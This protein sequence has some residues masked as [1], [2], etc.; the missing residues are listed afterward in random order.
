MQYYEIG[1]VKTWWMAKKWY[2][3]HLTTATF[4]LTYCPVPTL[5]MFPSLQV[6]VNYNCMISPF[7]QQSKRNFKT[8]L[9]EVCV[10]K[11][12]RPA[13]LPGCTMYRGSFTGPFSP[14]HRL[15]FPTWHNIECEAHL[16]DLIM[17]SQGNESGF[18]VSRQHG[19]CKMQISSSRCG[20]LQK[21]IL[22]GF[23]WIV[24]D[25]KLAILAACLKSKLK[26]FI[27]R[28]SGLRSYKL[29]FS[30]AMQ[31]QGMNWK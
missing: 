20:G 7:T 11:L 5:P 19:S 31:M 22:E 12:G 29:S 10:W 30:H 23:T 13:R 25:F 14:A 16:I 27:I 21:R 4:W 18:Q 17:I 24:S 28:L 6:F 3:C 8:D 15:R 26:Y 9:T 1:M 2:T